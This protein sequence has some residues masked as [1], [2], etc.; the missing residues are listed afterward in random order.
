MKRTL[1]FA[2]LG[3]VNPGKEWTIIPFPLNVGFIAAYTQKMLPELFD[4]RI[5]KNPAKFLEAIESEAPDVVAFSNYIWNK[6]LSV[7]FAKHLKSLH[8]DCITVMGGPNYNFTELEWV[9]KFARD[10]PEVDFHVEG[11]GEVK[12]YNLMACCDAHDFNLTAVKNASPAGVTYLDAETDK[13]VAN[14]ELNK[15]KTWSRF[16][17][18]GVDLTRGRLLDLNDVPSPYLTGLLDEFLKDPDYCPII[19]TNR[20]CPYSC[21]FC[22][23][24]AM[25]KSKS[26]TFAQ[27]RV[28]EEL[29]YIAENNQSVTPYLYVGDANFGLVPRDVEIAQ[30]LKELKTSKGFPQNVYMYFAKN[31]SEKVVRIAEILKDMT[32]ISLSRQTQND[33]VLENIKRSNISID[34]FNSLAELSK[35]LGIDSN[36][37]LIFGLPGESIKSFLDGVQEIVRQKVDGIHIFPAMLL[38]GSEMGTQASREHYGLTGEWRLIDGCAGE[39][40]PIRTMELEEIITKSKAITRDEYFQLRMFH[41][42][43]TLFLDT[44]IYKD[45]DVLLGEHSVVDLIVE[46]IANHQSAPAPIRDLLAEFTQQAKSEFFDEPPEIFTSEMIKKAQT[47]SVKLNPLYIARLLHRDGVRSAFHEYLTDLILIMGDASEEEIAG[48][49]AFIDASIYKF[50]DVMQRDVTMK[51]D[52]AAFARRQLYEKVNVSQFLL[53]EPKTFRY[54][55]PFTYEK[56]T[57]MHMRHPVSDQVYEILVHHTHET[58]RNTLLC[59]LQGES[60]KVLDWGAEA[61]TKDTDSNDRVIRLEGGWLY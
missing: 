40:G 36:V 10:V 58:F 25:G 34:T 14:I 27:D 7:A 44:K 54:V 31:S 8:P 59:R 49:L 35:K 9:E 47:Q 53:T 1:F 57:K 60:D 51:F 45:I 32:P 46:I 28:F 50:D 19:E 38:N 61:R 22:N 55:K 16:D 20:G 52:A 21:T 26:A 11:E 39:Y 43:Q 2:D 4:V 30:L 37:E 13:M 18:I 33:E 15:E 17:G 42:L 6:N 5:F 41:F 3:Y 56:F 12:F 48:I 24:G 29:H 23:W